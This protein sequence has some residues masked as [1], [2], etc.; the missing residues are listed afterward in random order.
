MTFARPRVVVTGLGVVSPLGADLGTTLSAL[1]ERRTAIRELTLFDARGFAQTLAAE[2]PDFDV[3]PF[4]RTPKALKTADRRARFAVAAAAQALVHAG[5]TEDGR[6]ELGVILGTAGGD[7]RFPDLLH[8]LRR[9]STTDPLDLPHFASQILS[10]TNPL[11]LIL[12]L[13]NM[14]S[15]HVGIQTGAQGPNNTLMGDEAAGLAAIGEAA[16]VLESGEARAMLAGGAESPVHAHSWASLQQQ[17]PGLPFPVPGEGAGIFLLELEASARA[18][19]ARILAT[20]LGAGT[21]ADGDAARAEE[22]AVRTALDR[23]GLK[24][25]ETTRVPRLS[26]RIGHLFAAAGPVA[27]ALATAG[28]APGAHILASAASISGM[29]SA[30]VL[31]LPGKEP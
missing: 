6:E 3:R 28:A 18:R 13:P 15:A 1:A 25:A 12:C 22:R 2:V 16:L 19:G 9:A 26:D 10:G 31:G 8:G 7:L 17:N 11:W 29:S 23:A 5:L 24:D 30:I 4:F 27:L 14:V 20:L 21:A